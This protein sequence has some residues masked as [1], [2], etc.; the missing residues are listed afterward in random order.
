MRATL[1]PLLMRCALALGVFAAVTALVL[2]FTGVPAR[3][4]MFPA[5]AELTWPDRCWR[6]IWQ[7]LG[8]FDPDAVPA[9]FPRY[10]RLVTQVPR[11]IRRMHWFCV[12]ATLLVLPL[13]GALVV[14]HVATRRHLRPRCRHCGVVLRG[15]ATCACAGCGREL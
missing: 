1:L 14:Y 3:P 8:L 7:R 5:Y 13:T 10:Q 15:L 2:W 9:R 6:A 12:D 11:T 4:V